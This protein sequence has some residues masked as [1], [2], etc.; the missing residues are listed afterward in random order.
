M[1]ETAVIMVSGHTQTLIN[2]PITN[3]DSFFSI[4][5]DLNALRLTGQSVAPISKD[6]HDHNNPRRPDEAAARTLDKKQF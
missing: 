1:D 6:K 5:V 4:L 2:Q 3:S